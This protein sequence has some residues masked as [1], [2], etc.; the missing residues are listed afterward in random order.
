MEPIRTERL[1]LRAPAEADLADFLAYRNA[2]ENLALQPIEPMEEQAAAKF[3]A[4]QAGQ[5]ANEAFGWIM[6]AIELQPERRMIGEVGIYIPEDGNQGDIGW[7]IHSPHQGKGYAT[8]AARALL[9][10][11]F[12]NRRLHRV[13]ATCD[14]RNAA[15]LSLMKQLGMRHEATFAKS[16]LVRGTWQSECVFAIL[17]EEFR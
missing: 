7:S 2:P 8:E 15:S 17:A 14:A 4:R 1:L 13:T 3:L 10:F 12:R 16:K 6:L 9:A 11:A 5:D